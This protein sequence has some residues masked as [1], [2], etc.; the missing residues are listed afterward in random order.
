[1][2][3]S[4]L[5]LTT[6]S[7]LL[8][9]LAGSGF[10]THQATLRVAQASPGPLLDVQAAGGSLFSGLAFRGISEYAS[11]GAGAATLTLSPGDAPSPLAHLAVDLA[12]G[13]TYTAVAVGG[14]GAL[15][16]F[17][18]L[19]DNRAPPP[20]QARV[21]FV[22][23]SPDA[24]PLDVALAGC[25]PLFSAIPFR[26]AGSYASVDAGTY[27]LELREAGSDRVLLSI[28][29]MSFDTA[30]VYTLYA[31]GSAAGLPRLQAVLSADA[32][33]GRVTAAP[34][35]SAAVRTARPSTPAVGA[36]PAGTTGRCCDATYTADQLSREAC[37]DHGGICEWWGP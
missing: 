20:G 32:G 23:A 6:V 14:P 22:H 24:P 11:L 18:L 37:R 1:M 28:P 12:P 4:L 34:P 30:T 8:V 17:L 31:V 21:R 33:P 3:R 15:Q 26:G 9:T 27:A 36:R 2:R 10:H 16:A 25:G 7:A 13:A 5:A 35:T 29:G 19:D